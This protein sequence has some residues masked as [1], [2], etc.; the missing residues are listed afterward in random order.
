MKVKGWQHSQRTVQG[1]RPPFGAGPVCAILLLP[2][3]RQPCDQSG[4]ETAG[5]R[6]RRCGA[7][8]LGCCRIRPP[9]RRLLL[10][11]RLP[12][13]RAAWCIGLC[14]AQTWGSASEPAVH[15]HLEALARHIEGCCMASASAGLHQQRDCGRCRGSTSAHRAA[16]ARAAALPAAGLYRLRCAA[17]VLVARS[18]RQRLPHRE[19][20]CAHAARV[21]V[22]PWQPCSSQT[23]SV[24]QQPSE[25]IAE[26]MPTQSGD[27]LRHQQ[28]TGAL[29]GGR[30]VAQASCSRTDDG[31]QRTK[32]LGR[33]LG[34][35]RIGAA[36]HAAAAA[37]AV[38]QTAIGVAASA[39]TVKR[40]RRADWPGAERLRHILPNT[41]AGGGCVR[42]CCSGP[43]R[44]I[45]RV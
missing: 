43:R 22:R 32:Q 15:T 29:A 2:P 24:G 6:G 40:P 14:C 44:L 17:T 12:C 34:G 45:V 20:L 35:R 25:G 21:R 1:C 7:L 42:G 13:C 30:L 18:Q 23:Q 11:F 10:L 33:Q 5:R 39:D 41:S 19:A 9:V 3:L 4:V 28:D 26:L 38:E 36:V 37:L 8:R 31:K 16:L 27:R